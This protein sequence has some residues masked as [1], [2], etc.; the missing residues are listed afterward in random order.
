MQL[1]DAAGEARAQAGGERPLRGRRGACRGE[2]TLTRTP[3]DQTPTR[4]ESGA[5]LAPER[6]RTSSAIA[7]SATRSRAASACTVSAAGSSSTVTSG[8]RSSASRS[9]R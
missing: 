1:G 9:S 6:E 2:L 3:S 8:V 5:V 4:M 7:R